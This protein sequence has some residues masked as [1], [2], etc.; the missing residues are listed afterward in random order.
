MKKFKNYGFTLSEVLITLAIIGIVAA[1]T[2]PTIMAN[3]TKQ[4]KSAKLKKAASVVSQ[5]CKKALA[6]NG[7]GD[8]RNTDLY[9]AVS[10]SVSAEE[11]TKVFSKYFNIASDVKIASNNFPF[12]EGYDN[13]YTNNYKYFTLTD[14]NTI[15]IN[16]PSD[17]AKE[18]YKAELE[19]YVD[20]DS[21]Y[22]GLNITNDDVFHVPITSS[23]SFALDVN[24][25]DSLMP[26]DDIEICGRFVGHGELFDSKCFIEIV[27][28]NW[29]FNYK[30]SY[31][32]PLTKTNIKNYY[33]Y[34][35][36]N[37]G[38]N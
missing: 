10:S 37:N 2:V 30:R 24:D 5:A 12:Q 16:L 4:A 38:E 15:L 19:F 23:G 11:A 25:K 7:T 32:P 36:K 28:N 21:M 29:Q 33:D 8:I 1:I 14:G 27:K 17:L 18:I 26:Y 9:Q 22:K 35:M 34:Y 20:L 6:D 31:Y 13:H 3:Y